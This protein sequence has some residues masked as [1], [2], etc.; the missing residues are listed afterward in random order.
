[1]NI[2]YARVSSHGQNLDSQI[3]KLIKAGCK[4]ENIFT[5]KASGANS[6]REQLIHMLGFI[7]KGDVLVI[8]KLDR[9]A[10]S[11]KDFF[12]IL[13]EIEAKGASLSI[14]DMNLDTG[15]SQGRLMMGVLSS[16]AEFERNLI[17]ERQQDGIEKAKKEGKHLGRKPI[18]EKTKSLILADIKDGMTKQA[19]A[20]K[21]NIGVASV[22]NIVRE[23]RRY[24]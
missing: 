13:G 9:L 2:G 18:S 7:R 8:T 23:A 17:R 24:S 4:K 1:M 6:E 16:V 20:D 10:R 19:T 5:E 11:M 21:H 22:Y 14:L 3:D 12:N 15:S